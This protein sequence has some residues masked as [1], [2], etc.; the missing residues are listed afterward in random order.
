MSDSISE[1]DRRDFINEVKQGAYDSK[2]EDHI[3]SMSREDIA[4][5]IGLNSDCLGEMFNRHIFPCEDAEAWINKHKEQ[6][7]DWW[8]RKD[9]ILGLIRQ[10]MEHDLMNEAESV[11]DDS[12][13]QG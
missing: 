6:L 10:Q 8:I 4:G 2:V 1:E 11:I 5:V 3:S 13:W 9:I 7:A 12:E